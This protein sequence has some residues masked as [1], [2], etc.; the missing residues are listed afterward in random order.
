MHVE[1]SGIFGALVLI[2]AL[3]ALVNIAQSPA[4]VGAKVAWMALVLV[5]PVL[6]FFAWLI[7]GPRA[8][9]RP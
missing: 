8:G 4:S 3:Y 2:A 9:T 6:G 1:V 7:G 5:L